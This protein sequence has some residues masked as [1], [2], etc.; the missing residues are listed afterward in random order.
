MKRKWKWIEPQ[1]EKRKVQG[2]ENNFKR[3]WNNKH[4]Q[5]KK[6]LAIS[7]IPKMIKIG[8]TKM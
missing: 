6:T 7:K 8:Q 2:Y 4:V 3:K 5:G 1:M